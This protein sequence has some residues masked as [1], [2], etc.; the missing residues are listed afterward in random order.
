LQNMKKQKKTRLTQEGLCA[1][2]EVGD[3]WVLA[4]G[5]HMYTLSDTCL[6]L[7]C[8]LWVAIGDGNFLL[9]CANWWVIWLL[10]TLISLSL[11]CHSLVFT[12]FTAFVGTQNL[13]VFRGKESN[14]LSYFFGSLLV[15]VL[16]NF[17]HLWVWEIVVLLLRN[18]GGVWY[19]AALGM[20]LNRWLQ[21]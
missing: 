7:D 18:W 12:H 5:C 4:S 14:G 15:V 11:S 9:I 17:N 1:W 16:F 2:N 21:H 3:T 13:E 8:R 6:W 19:D 10:C 20:Q